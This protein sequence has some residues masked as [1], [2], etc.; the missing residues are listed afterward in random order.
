MHLNMLNKLHAALP[1]NI[2]NAVLL[3][4]TLSL[5]V[6]LWV[7]YIG[8]VAARAHK[9]RAE[10]VKRL[11]ETSSVIGIAS[12]SDFEAT[13]KGVL[14]LEKFGKKHCSA[15]WTEMNL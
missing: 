15:I 2:I 13:L 8:A 1:D 9:S 5:E 6:L 12:Q 11:K 10:F 7:L 3:W 4:D 14:W